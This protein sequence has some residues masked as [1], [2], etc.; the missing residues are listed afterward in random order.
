[1]AAT[2]ADA[3]SGDTWRIG[4]ILYGRLRELCADLGIREGER[5]DCIAAGPSVLLLRTGR[6]RTVSLERAE[7]RF[8]H[9]ETVDEVDPMAAF[10]PGVAGAARFSSS[11]T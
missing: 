3:R 1:M 6:D 9:G 8:I 5:V 7:A 11:R 10:A 2:L 4:R